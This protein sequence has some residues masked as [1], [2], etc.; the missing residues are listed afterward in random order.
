MLGEG[1][2]SEVS[3]SVVVGDEVH[4]DFAEE[5]RESH[6]DGFGSIHVGHHCRPHDVVGGLLPHKLQKF[7]CSLPVDPEEMISRLD[8]CF[9]A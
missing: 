1:D 5:Q 8:C 6:L 3:D 7:V 2:P 9:P 4:G